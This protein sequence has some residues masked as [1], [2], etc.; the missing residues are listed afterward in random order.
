[1][2]LRILQMEGNEIEEVPLGMTV[3]NEL[4]M[5]NMKKNRLKVIPD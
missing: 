1:M 4:E 3:L 5:L 2:G